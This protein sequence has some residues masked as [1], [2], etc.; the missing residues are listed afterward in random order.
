MSEKSYLKT[1]VNSNYDNLLFQSIQTIQKRGTPLGV[2]I[3]FSKDSST[4]NFFK[5]AL[6][7]RQFNFKTDM[8]S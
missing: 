3:F 8:K 1:F 7:I 4:T 5:T 6:P 2:F